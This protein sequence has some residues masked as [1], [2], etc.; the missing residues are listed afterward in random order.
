MHPDTRA[1]ADHMHEFGL[2]ILGQALHKAT[3]SE[4]MNEFAHP[5]SVT[6]AAQAAEILIKARVAQEHPLLIF[7]SLPKALDGEESL[8]IEVLLE[9]GRSAQYSELPD[10]LWAVTGYRLPERQEYDSFG[11]LRNKIQHLSIPPNVPLA[12]RTLEFVFKVVAPMVRDF[13]AENVIDTICGVDPD[14]IEYLQDRLDD[15]GIS[16]EK[17]LLQVDDPEGHEEDRTA[18]FL[19]DDVSSPF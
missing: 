18:T 5:L 15:L 16:Y 17:S 19:P 11:R 14:G 8:D 9:S 4:L 13:W 7:T 12:N 2:G 1:M 3:F 10:L 6:I